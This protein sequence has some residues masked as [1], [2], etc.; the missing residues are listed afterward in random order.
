[1]MTNLDAAVHFLDRSSSYTSCVT[2]G[3]KQ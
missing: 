3:A 1:M 2:N